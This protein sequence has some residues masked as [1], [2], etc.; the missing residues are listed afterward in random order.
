VFSIEKK[1]FHYQR[2]IKEEICLPFRQKFLYQE[3]L[4]SLLFDHIL[5][6]PQR[7]PKQLK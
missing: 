2:K 3:F 5:V 6:E 1:V 7:I 4:Y